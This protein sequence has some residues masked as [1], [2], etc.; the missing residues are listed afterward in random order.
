[1]ISTLMGTETCLAIQGPAGQLEVIAGEPQEEPIGAWGV[2]CHPHPLFGG[3]MHNKVVTTMVKVFQYLGLNTVRFNFRGVGKSEGKF[4]EGEGELNDLL[5]VIEWVQHTHP[6]RDIW[7]AGFS[8]G[9]YI[10]AK[11][12]TQFPVKKLVTIAPPVQNF[13]MQNIPPITCPWILVQGEV[14]EIVAPQAVFA[15]AENREPKPLILRFPQ[16]THFFHGQLGELRSRLEE[17]L[18]VD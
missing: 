13:P 8:F 12:A 15:W 16:A 10:A 4:D 7:L 14:D 9:A 3:T 18:M 5:A 1:M 17:A 6:H 2:V 11:A